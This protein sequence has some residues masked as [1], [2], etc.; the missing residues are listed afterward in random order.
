MATLIRTAFALLG[1]FALIAGACTVHAR[2]P[3]DADPGNE[4]VPARLVLEVELTS[5]AVAAADDI[6]VARAALAA[7]TKGLATVEVLPPSERGTS[8]LLVIPH[9]GTALTRLQWLSTDP[10]GLRVAAFDASE[11]A[12]QLDE[13]DVESVELDREKAGLALRIASGGQERFERL[14]RGLIG[15]RLAVDVGSTRVSSPV[16]QM[17][18]RTTLFIDGGLDELSPAD[19]RDLQALIESPLSGLRLRPARGRATG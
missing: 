4:A 16:V 6:E 18:M 2:S 19:M 1:L 7:R 5:G 11:G 17:P 10:G 8:R 9:Q 12:I 3:L 15:R 14:T 13:T